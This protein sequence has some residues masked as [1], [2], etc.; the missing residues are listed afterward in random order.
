MSCDAHVIGFKK[1]LWQLLVDSEQELA[2]IAGRD[3]NSEPPDYEVTV[4]NISLRR[5]TKESEMI[6]TG[7]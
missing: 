6:R 1:K 7:P 4:L 3:W 5:S 2:V